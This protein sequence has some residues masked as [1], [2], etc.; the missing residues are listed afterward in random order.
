MA[1]YDWPG[2]VRELRNLIESMVVQDQ[3]RRPRTWT[4]CRKATRSRRLPAGG[5]R[6][7]VPAAWSAGR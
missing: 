7:A 1:A 4:T 2:N 6:P 5:Q 3:R